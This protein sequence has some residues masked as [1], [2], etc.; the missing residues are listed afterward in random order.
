MSYFYVFIYYFLKFLVKFCPSFILKSF[1]N[2]IAFCFFKFDKKHT[3]IIK[4]NLN[5]CQIEASDELILQIYKNYAKFALEFLKN[6]DKTK[7]QILKDIVFENEEIMQEA[8]NLGRPVIIQTAHYGN[9][10]LLSLATA[11]KFGALSIIG[12]RLD[13]EKMDE[14]LSKNRKRFEIELIDKK[15][16]AKPSLMALKNNRILG[17]LTDQNTAKSEGLEIE[18]FGKKALH[19]PAASIFAKK[20]KALIV[21]AF[22]YQKDNKY[23]VKFMPKIDILSLENDEILQATKAQAKATEMMIRQKPD[24]YFW[25]HARFKHFYEDLYA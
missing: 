2:F 23:I 3:K 4:T 15:N 7:D 16:A 21:P 11:A 13:D 24:E 6:Q 20:T 22:I 9:W 25:F 14:I 10:E 8:R 18:F 5:L 17:I 1:G 12:R 19:T